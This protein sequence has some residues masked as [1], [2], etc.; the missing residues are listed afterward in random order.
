MTVLAWVN[1]RIDA[2]SAGD[3]LFAKTVSTLASMQPSLILDRNNTGQQL[4]DFPATP[5]RTA[6]LPPIGGAD[7]PIGDHDEA[8]LGLEIDRRSLG[9]IV[10]RQS[11]AGTRGRIV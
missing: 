9:V 5:N 3:P 10:E 6:H 7:T 4:D 8:A 1:S 2:D 11:R